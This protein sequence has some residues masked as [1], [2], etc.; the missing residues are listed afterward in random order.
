[1]T[2]VYSYIYYDFAKALAGYNVD[3]T[4][5]DVLE[6][7]IKYYGYNTDGAPVCPVCGAVKKN[8]RGLLS[9][10]HRSH[11]DILS[12][13]TR[14]AEKVIWFTK[15]NMVSRK[16]KFRCRICGFKDNYAVKVRKH[17]IEEHI[18][19]DGMLKLN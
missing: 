18:L 14:Q 9:H 16:S 19:K 13:L 8:K 17:I 15:R 10:I 12:F 2:I 11:K 6:F 3:G 5:S 4:Y 1:M 7:I